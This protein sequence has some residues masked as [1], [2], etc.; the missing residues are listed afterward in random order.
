M[1]GKAVKRKKPANVAH[2]DNHREQAEKNEEA[3]TDAQAFT[4]QIICDLMVIALHDKFGFGYDRCK[5]V[6]DEISEN[7]SQY[8]KIWHEDTQDRE[9]AKEVIDRRLKEICGDKFQPWEVRYSI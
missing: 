6:T 4:A 8:W 3:L 9:Y 2:R 1:N 7:Y 5:R